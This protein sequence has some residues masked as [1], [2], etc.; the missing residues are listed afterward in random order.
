[1]STQSKG[2]FPDEYKDRYEE[3]LNRRYRQYS[4]VQ[5]FVSN[6]KPEQGAALLNEVFGFEP[7]GD[8]EF[9]LSAV[10]LHFV[11]HNK[12]DVRRTYYVGQVIQEDNVK[13]RTKQYQD[14]EKNHGYAIRGL[15]HLEYG[16]LENALTFENR[17]WQTPTLEQSNDTFK[18]ETM[19]QFNMLYDPVDIGRGEW[20]NDWGYS[21]SKVASQLSELFK[22]GDLTIEN[23]HPILL[24]YVKVLCEAE[25]EKRNDI[26]RDEIL[27][28][29]ANYDGVF[30][31]WDTIG[32]TIK[33]GYLPKYR[34]F[35][36]KTI[37]I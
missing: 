20:S 37:D 36:D 23:A 8:V 26:T 27:A 21:D 35:I 4:E 22:E 32:N 16:F 13:L 15:A 18:H 24:S 28:Q 31:D 33:L 1:M 12:E 2:R 9:R 3:A 30:H 5:E 14:L 7:E 10:G 34:K 17:A 29:A 11:L 19:H 25:R 6:F